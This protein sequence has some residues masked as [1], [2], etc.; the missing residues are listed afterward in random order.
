MRPGGQ[1]QAEGRKEG[2]WDRGNVLAHQK[3]GRLSREGGFG[4]ESEQSSRRGKVKLKD[5]E[6]EKPGSQESEIN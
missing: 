1:R 2:S 4:G 5:A 6:R 3:N